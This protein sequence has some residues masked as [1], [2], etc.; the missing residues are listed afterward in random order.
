MAL[1]KDYQYISREE[2]LQGEKNS[3][4]KHEYI[5]GEVYAMAG[6]SKAHIIIGGN[7]FV[8]L[9]NHLRGHRCFPYSSDMKVHI[10]SKNVYYYPD[11]VVTC[12]ERDREDDYVL[13]YPKFIVEVLSKTTEAFDRGNKFAD[14]GQ[15]ETLEEYVL[16]S[17]D[18]MRVESFRRNSE[19]Q[20]V[21]Y[22]FEEGDEIK[23]TSVNFSCSVSA[24][25]EDVV[26]EASKS[27][28]N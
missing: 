21:L 17:Q 13:F 16:I 1:S 11:L 19:G 2:Y 27:S 12:D 9:R 23:L 5:N 25:Y 22:R 10:E 28:E 15:L 8:L 18:I 7:I 6:A 24:I 26:F 4:I 20:W 14:Y 3:Q